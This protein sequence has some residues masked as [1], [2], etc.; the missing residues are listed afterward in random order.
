MYPWRRLQVT[1]CAFAVFFPAELSSRCTVDSETGS[2]WTKRNGKSQGA[3]L[4]DYYFERF[5]RQ[6]IRPSRQREWLIREDGRW[7]GRA[8][9][10]SSY[11]AVI[12]SLSHRKGSILKWQLV[13][14]STCQHY[15][16][17]PNSLPLV[18]FL[19]LNTVFYIPIMTAMCMRNEG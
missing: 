17:L 16:C 11:T 3:Q 13:A 6:Q 14:G 18:C 15:T 4:E 5:F 1:L 7:R 9:T 12:L 19:H 8:F 2:C 10:S